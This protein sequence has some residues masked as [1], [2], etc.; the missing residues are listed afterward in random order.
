MIL[1]SH[2]TA[3]QN[4]RQAALALAEDD[5][6]SEFWTCLNWKQGGFFDRHLPARLRNELRR[7]SFPDR[8]KPFTRTS[9]WRE[10]GRLLSQQLGLQFLTRPEAGP[11]SV[12]AV[13]LSL[14]REVARR[15]QNSR[16]L[17]AV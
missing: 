15:L 7:R 17:K 5:L 13:Y 11:F 4:V 1:L 14:D 6:L 8:V 10:A 2:P 16:Q 9:G 3:N 12:D